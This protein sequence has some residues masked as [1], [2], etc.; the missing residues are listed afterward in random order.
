MFARAGAS[1][2]LQVSVPQ[3]IYLRNRRQ[4]PKNDKQGQLLKREA[5][6]Q[7]TSIEP[8]LDSVASTLAPTW[9]LYAS[10]AIPIPSVLC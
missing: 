1:I 7:A 8:G 10:C 9:L 3:R 6:A 4:P 5:G 2:A